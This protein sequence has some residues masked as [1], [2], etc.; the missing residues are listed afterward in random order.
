MHAISCQVNILPILHSLKLTGLCFAFFFLCLPVVIFPSLQEAIAQKFSILHKIINNESMHLLCLENLTESSA[1]RGGKYVSLTLYWKV[2]K[3]LSTFDFCILNCISLLWGGRVLP[4]G[5]Y[6]N[7]S[8][9]KMFLE[10]CNT[11]PRK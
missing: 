7:K 5:H 6:E 2:V 11:Q 9:M 3:E 1:P 10:K 4:S 8:C